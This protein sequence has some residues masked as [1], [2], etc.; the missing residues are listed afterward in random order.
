MV[1]CVVIFAGGRGSRIGNPEKMLLEI[2]NRPIISILIEILAKYFK[3]ILVITSRFHKNLINLLKRDYRVDLIVLPARD[4]C[5]DLCYIINIVRPRPLLLLPSDIVVRNV[6]RFL[7][8]ISSVRSVVDIVTLA[9]V[10]GTPLGVSIVYSDKCIPGV[11]LSWTCV[12]VFTADDVVDVDTLLDYD[13][14]KRSMR[15]E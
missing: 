2:C 4:Y 1:K 5:E 9:Y 8:A 13:V 10:D 6:E 15:C 14:V 12:N 7:Y 11:E 3:N